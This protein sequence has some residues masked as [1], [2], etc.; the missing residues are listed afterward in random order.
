MWHLAQDFS[1]LP[2]LSSSFIVDEPPVDRV[3]AVTTEPEILFDSYFKIKCARPM[4][5]YSV[6][7]LMDHF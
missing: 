7:G 5:V 6:P 2:T 4:P 1:A 3:V